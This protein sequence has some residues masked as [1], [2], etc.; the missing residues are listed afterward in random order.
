V[1][2][3]VIAADGKVLQVGIVNASSSQALDQ[4]AEAML[5]SAQLPAPLIQVTR[6]IRLHYRLAN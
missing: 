3:I 5:R 6:T 2:R 1:L 4:G